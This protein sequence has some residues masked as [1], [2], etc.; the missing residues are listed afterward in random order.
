MSNILQNLINAETQVRWRANA[1]AGIAFTA[2]YEIEKKYE[3][4]GKYIEVLPYA[5]RSRCGDV[6]MHIA[7]EY[8]Y[9]TSP[10]TDISKNV[11]LTITEELDQY[12]DFGVESY[13]LLIPKELAFD[14][15]DEELYAF[16]LEHFE[17][18][19]KRSHAQSEEY[20]Y[21][22]LFKMDKAKIKAFVDNIPDDFETGETIGSEHKAKIEFLKTHSIL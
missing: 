13:S 20:L 22:E 8:D 4:T 18:E 3:K 12:E 16:M 9:S 21:I 15:T 14:G 17:K 6:S 2:S 5:C 7:T 10:P 1:I 11:R 19:T